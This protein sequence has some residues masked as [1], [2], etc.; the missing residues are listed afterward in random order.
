MK[1]LRIALVAVT[2]TVFGA[3]CFAGGFAAALYVDKQVFGGLN[4]GRLHQ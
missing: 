4:R 2:G 1:V 3:G